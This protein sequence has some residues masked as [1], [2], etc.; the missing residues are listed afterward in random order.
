MG[1]LVVPDSNEAK[2]RVKWEAGA[3]TPFGP[4]QRPYRYRPL[5]TW[6]HKAGPPE[7]GLGAITVVDSELAESEVRV[8]DLHQRGYHENPAEAIAAYHA[9]QTEYMKLAGER[10]YDV[11]HTLSPKAAAEALAAEA[12]H[13]GHLPMVPE[14]P[15]VRRQPKEGVK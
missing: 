14:T 13:P 15:I 9:Q 3:Y 2:E 8:T 11:Q 7:G 10:N 5:P 6:L 1:V 12:A 4:G